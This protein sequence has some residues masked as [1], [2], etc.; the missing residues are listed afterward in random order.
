MSAPVVSVSMVVCNVERF[1]AEAIESVLGQ[2]LRN[3]EFVIVD[4]G[5][6]DG[7]LGIVSSYAARDG[8]IRLRQVSHCGLA[9]ARNACCF[10]AQGKYLAIMDA[11]D[12]ALPERLAREVEFLEANPAV[13]AVGG[14]VEWIDA[15]G[16]SVDRNRVPMGVA[17]RPLTQ[18]K[19]IR[20]ALLT[21]N[22]I[23]QPSVLMRTE[24]FAQV[25]GYRPAFAPSEDYDLWLRISEHFELANLD[26]VILKYRIH[27]SQVSVRKRT[28][29][30]YGFLAARASALS[31]K[32][33][34]FD[35]M[36]SVAEITPE[37][38]ASLGVTPSTQQNA[39]ASDRR[40]WI[41][42]L[43]MAGEDSAALNAALEVLQSDLKCTERWQIADLYLTVAS[44]YWRQGKFSSSAFAAF[45]ALATRPAITLRP[46]KPL[47]QRLGLA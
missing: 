40:Q 11:D 36:N 18:N 15:A 9:E 16:A 22:P 13:G 28:Q 26:E 46:L 27:P 37:V 17:D 30:T 7:T 39:L 10:L 25:G 42:H 20:S 12:V 19:E 34:Q 24:A 38:L 4:F 2:T 5:S 47:F 23:W 1:L 32:S 45:R 31:R 6:T 29:Q 35:P 33:G 43:C 8:R 21:Y 44:L 41:R 3:F 14:A